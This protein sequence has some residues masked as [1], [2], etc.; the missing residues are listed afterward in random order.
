MVDEKMIR[1]G[2]AGWFS[3]SDDYWDDK[4]NTELYEIYVSHGDWIH[5]IQF[6]YVVDG[7]LVLSEPHGTCNGPKFNAVRL[8]YPTEFII[9]ITGDC[10]PNLKLSSLTIVT[11]LGSYGPFGRA[12]SSRIFDFQLG[13]SRQFGGFYG[14]CDK[15]RNNCPAALGVY[16]KPSTKVEP[17]GNSISVE[18]KN[19]EDQCDI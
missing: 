8:K 3:A 4:G 6:Q 18:T 1:V 12:T 5:S 7:T 13:I 17:I 14:Y 10:F 16:F 19:M 2:P 9:G 15:A 11:N